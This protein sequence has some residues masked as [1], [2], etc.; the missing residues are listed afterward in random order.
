VGKV[1]EEEGGV[2]IYRV[3]ERNGW[4]GKPMAKKGGGVEEEKTICSCRARFNTVRD[5]LRTHVLRYDTC[6]K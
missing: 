2:V 6:V 5:K 3:E 4:N 1:G